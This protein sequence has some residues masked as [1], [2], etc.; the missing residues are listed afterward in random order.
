MRKQDDRCSSK[1]VSC[2]PYFRILFSESPMITKNPMQLKA[3]IKNK[4]AEKHI[5]AQLVMQNYMSAQR[6]FPLMIPVIPFKRL[7]TQSWRKRKRLPYGLAGSAG[8]DYGD[9]APCE[10][11]R[12][13]FFSLGLNRNNLLYSA[14]RQRKLPSGSLAIWIR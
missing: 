12:T 11:L 14:A 5:S 7:W 4:A 13:G 8:R 6:T 1:E 9:W 10:Y 2:L 3:F